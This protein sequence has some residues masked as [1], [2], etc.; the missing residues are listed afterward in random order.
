ML[1]SYDILGTKPPIDDEGLTAFYMPFRRSDATTKNILRSVKP[2]KEYSL[3]FP[4]I[5]GATS[6]F[7]DW[8][9]IGCVSALAAVFGGIDQRAADKFQSVRNLLHQIALWTNCGS[10]IFFIDSAFLEALD[11]TDIPLDYDFST[12]EL[13]FESLAFVLPHKH[14]LNF[15]GHTIDYLT[16]SRTRA[17]IDSPFAQIEIPDGV[18]KLICTT[19]VKYDGFLAPGFQTNAL[20][21]IVRMD[22]EAFI[23]E[24]ESDG[25]KYEMND[26]VFAH[27]MLVTAVKIV[28]A[29]EAAPELVERQS[30]P[31]TRNYTKQGIRET[32]LPNVVGRKLYTHSINANH[33]HSTHRM[34]WRRGHFRRQPF[35]S[36]VCQC[37]HTKASH[38][39]GEMCQMDCQCEQYVVHQPT[40]TL[41]IKPMLIGVSLTN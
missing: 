4:K 6:K 36:K 40:K 10:P 28:L 3:L 26:A 17:S 24:A 13:P 11:K 23:R 19:S 41:W 30:R 2:L 29:M 12:F 15:K 16:L 37:S 27:R 31:L 5:Y 35:G 20:S 9:R 25:T 7:R 22:T 33:G 32:W 1:T 34:H 14:S 39:N 21:E 18:D 38:L 8:H